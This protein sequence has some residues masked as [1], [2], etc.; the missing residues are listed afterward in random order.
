MSKSESVLDKIVATK[1]HEIVRAKAALP[2]EELLVRIA[3]APPVRDFFAALAAPGVIKLIAEVKKASPSAGLIRKDFD[4]VEIALAYANHGATCLSCLTD[5]EYFQGKLDYLA[6]IREAV[7]LPILRKDFIVDKYQVLEAVLLIAECLTDAELKQL[8][9]YVIELEMTPLVEF[10]AAENRQRVL[11]IG[12]TLVGV[13]NRNL[14]TF[15]TDL[16]HTIAM[17][18]ELPDECLLVAESGIGTPEDV[19][20]LAGEGVAAML[21]GESLMRQADIGAAV[22]NLLS[23]VNVK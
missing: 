22:E 19:A 3:D 9:D 7:S 23:L 12:A 4:P 13:N 18:S 2:T 16:Q 5:E 8:Y 1:R 15:E 20:M 6:Q 17:Q 21:V 10:Y 14:H 11:D